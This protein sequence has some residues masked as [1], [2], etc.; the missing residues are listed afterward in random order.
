M[1]RK[2]LAVLLIIIAGLGLI[3]CVGGLIGTWV[4]NTPMTDAITA[5]AQTADSY[6]ALVGNAT[7]MAS[8]QVGDVRTQLDEIGDRVENMTA[9]TRSE[10]ANQISDAVKHRLGPAVSTL[11][12]TAATLRTG[13]IAL[14]R[15]LEN[16]NRIPGVNVPTLTGELQAADQ[17]LNEIN[18]RLTALTTSIADV[19]VDGSQV[20]SLIAST[21]DQLASVEDLFNQWN[22]QIETVSAAIAAASTTA[23]GLIDLA[24]VILSLLLIL[25]GAGQVC[26]ILRGVELFRAR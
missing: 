4:A 11:R 8:N 3:L 24:S 20:E 13:I 9:E 21:A 14:N 26:L 6:L 15:S 7:A 25:F 5:T 23:P 10:I 1:I 19:S 22:T 18:D 16:A 17:R 12:T 2:I